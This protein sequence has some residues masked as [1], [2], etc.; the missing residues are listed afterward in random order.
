MAKETLDRFDKFSPRDVGV[1]QV[2]ILQHSVHSLNLSSLLLVL[3][4]DHHLWVP[5]AL[6]GI[7]AILQGL[8]Q[9]V[10]IPSKLDANLLELP[11]G[12]YSVF[13]IVLVLRIGQV[14][15]AQSGK[16]KRS[17]FFQ[18]GYFLLVVMPI[19]SVLEISPAVVAVGVDEPYQ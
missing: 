11:A 16:A 12:H 14:L 19:S 5:L 8:E 13:A 2:D 4:D 15:C 7:S 1:V 6:L 18:E 17:H 10:L 3:L 9:A